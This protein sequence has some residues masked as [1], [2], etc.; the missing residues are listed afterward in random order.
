V[1]LAAAIAGGSVPA[2]PVFAC[3][4]GNAPLHVR[5]K[6]IEAAEKAATK[7]SS[8]AAPRTSR[9]LLARWNEI[10]RKMIVIAEDLPEDKGDY[11][12][13]PASRSFIDELLHASASMSLFTNISQGE[14][15]WRGDDPDRNEFRDRRNVVAYVKQCVQDGRDLITL[16]GDDEA[17]VTV[18]D[19]VVRS[20][21]FQ[22]LLFALIGHA[23]E[24]YEN[25]LAYYRA[26]GLV[27]P[28]ARQRSN[29]T[30]ELASSGKC[31]TSRLVWS[32]HRK[33]VTSQKG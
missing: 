8:K 10:G 27:P 4:K 28:E 32:R 14:E 24:H 25:L 1:L 11:R 18:G 6:K 2:G 20:I 19:S 5:H 12:P 17:K 15:Q 13:S 9:E 16:L 26:N 31:S 3:A 23:E 30:F 29:S 21:R 7:N 33:Q 22:D